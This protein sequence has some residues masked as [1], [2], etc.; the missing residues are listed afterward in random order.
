MRR[1]KASTFTQRFWFTELSSSFTTS[2][3][4]AS[5]ACSCSAASAALSPVT[6]AAVPPLPT[7]RPSPPPPPPPPPPAPP[8]F[9]PLRATVMASKYR[10]NRVDLTD[11]S[12]TGAF[13]FTDINSA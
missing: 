3:T 4:T 7:P 8:N 11:G 9:L 5:I 1:G 12:E 2:C 10:L 6:P 13:T